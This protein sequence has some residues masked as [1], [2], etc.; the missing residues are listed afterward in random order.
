[1]DNLPALNL[2]RRMGYRLVEKLENY[3]G[4]GRD[5]YRAVKKLANRS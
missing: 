3:Y 5:A 4:A 2:Y 1:M